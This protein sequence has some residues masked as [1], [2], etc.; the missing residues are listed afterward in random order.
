M[1]TAVLVVVLMR[2]GDYDENFTMESARH[3]VKELTS[4]AP[5][6]AHVEQNRVNQEVPGAEAKL[7]GTVIMC[8][9]E[10]IAVDGD[11]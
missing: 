2:I 11:Y 6:T 10:K 3:T 5:Q 1:C 9:G 7:D 8:S 4:F